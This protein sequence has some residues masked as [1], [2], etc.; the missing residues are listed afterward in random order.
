MTNQTRR[1]FLKKLFQSLAVLSSISWMGMRVPEIQ[2]DPVS[3]NSG[4]LSEV[5][6]K[7]TVVSDYWDMF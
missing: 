3:F 6:R 4:K 7:R 1:H 5:L 2:K